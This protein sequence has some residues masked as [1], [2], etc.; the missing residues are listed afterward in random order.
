MGAST[1]TQFVHL[2]WRNTHWRW[3]DRLWSLHVLGYIDRDS[4]AHVGLRIL[5]G[6][7]LLVSLTGVA[8]LVSTWGRRRKEARA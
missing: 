7:A 4:P 8:L 2:A 1:D 5:G 6:L 3:F